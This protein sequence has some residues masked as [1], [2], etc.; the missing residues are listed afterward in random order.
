MTEYWWLAVTVLAV[1]A[2]YFVWG[3]KVSAK[4]QQE[5]ATIKS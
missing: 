4:A 1:V 3:R 5:K 2:I